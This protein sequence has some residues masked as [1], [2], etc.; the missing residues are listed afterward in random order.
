MKT[1]SFRVPYRAPSDGWV[2]I[3]AS[4]WPGTSSNAMLLLHMMPATRTSWNGFAQALNSRGWHVLAPDLR[5][6]GDSV[7]SSVGTLDFNAFDDDGHQMSILDVDG[8]RQWLASAG[9][10]N[11]RISLG[12]ASIGAN[13]A[14]QDMASHSEVR[15]GFLLSPGLNYHGIETEP[16]IR[17]LGTTQRLFLAAA[18]DDEESAEALR[19]L[20][21]MRQSGTEAQL[22]PSG[23]HGTQLFASHPDLV[24]ALA[25]W[26]SAVS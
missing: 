13:L 21:A 10:A 1:V 7:R 4:Y 24:T 2:E 3:V 9:I 5:G 12:G 15:S 26:L 11:D 19:V 23:G 14:L 18:E 25:D 16:L 22:F 17:H 20:P 8:A 6:H